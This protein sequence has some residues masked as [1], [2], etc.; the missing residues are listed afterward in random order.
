MPT[1]T[2]TERG[3][4][5]GGILLKQIVNVDDL[6]RQIQP[7][8]NNAEFSEVFLSRDDDRLRCTL[9]RVVYAPQNTNKSHYHFHQNSDCAFY[10]LAG[11]GEFLVDK[12]SW[13]RIRPGDLIYN[14]AGQVHGVRALSADQPVWYLSVTGPMPFSTGG[15]DG[16]LYSVGLAGPPRR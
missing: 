13:T 16:R 14:N 3:Y 6:M 11:A 12:D 10:I 7:D 15:L 2:R 5:V 4:E 8:P 9:C 1:I